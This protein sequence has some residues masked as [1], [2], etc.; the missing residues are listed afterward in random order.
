MAAQIAGISGSPVKNSNTARLIQHV[1]KSSGLKTEF[2]KL[3]KVKVGPC[4]A[5][6]GCT[7]DNVCKVKDDFQELAEKVNNWKRNWPSVFARCS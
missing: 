6:L 7:K 5:C 3:S 2:V 1:L 4:I